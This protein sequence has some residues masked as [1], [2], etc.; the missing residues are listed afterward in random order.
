MGNG[1]TGKTRALHT[2][3]RSA[4]GRAPPQKIRAFRLVSA[5][6]LAFSSPMKPGRTLLE[7]GAASCSDAELLAILLGSGGRG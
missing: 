5:H 3:N 4:P 6:G 7:S 2:D 1:Y